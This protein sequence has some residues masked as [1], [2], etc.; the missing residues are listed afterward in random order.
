MHRY[1]AG[2]EVSPSSLRIHETAAIKRDGC[3]LSDAMVRELRVDV[4]PHLSRH[5]D[6][7][8]RQQLDA[9]DDPLVLR[10]VNSLQRPEYPTGVDGLKRTLH[11]ARFVPSI[12]DELARER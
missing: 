3:H 12:E 4:L 7:F 9:Q 1:Q 2:P 10:P 11:L 5:I 6:A 8:N